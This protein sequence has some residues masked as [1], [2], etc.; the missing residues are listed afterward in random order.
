MSLQLDL[1]QWVLA[2]VGAALVGL[3]KTGI[4]GLGILSVAIYATV[5]PARESVGIL[6]VILVLT[7]FVAVSVYRRDASWSHLARLFPWAGAGVLIGFVAFGSMNDELVRTVIGGILVALTALQLFQRRE[8]HLPIEENPNR[9]LVALTGL[10]AGFTTMIANAA[11]P[12]M[13]LYLLAM[14]LPKYTFV[15]TAAWFF[16]VLNLFKVPFSIGL[17]L[18]DFDS[19]GLSLRMA[20]FAIAGALSGRWVISHMNQRMFE[21]AALLLTLAAGLRMLVG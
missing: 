14:R 15:G 13:I 5:L 7:D 19:L 1:W 8:G 3:A 11:G 12:L 17:G 6:L 16:L 20:P 18:I 10:G 9:W 2:A 4:A 21:A